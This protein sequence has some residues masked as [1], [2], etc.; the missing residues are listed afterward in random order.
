MGTGTDDALYVAGWLELKSGP[1][2]LHVPDMSGRYYSLQFTDPAS[3]A[4]FAY[5]GTRATGTRSGDYL[6]PS[7]D[8][9][10]PVPAGM[11]RIPVPHGAALL[12]G[13]VFVDGDGDQ[14]AAYALAQQIRLA[15]L[16]P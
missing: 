4:N 1:Q 12:I 11:T 2:I 5:V 13:R 9:N 10:G 8:W 16:A 14:P 7:P 15:P 6:L 3:S